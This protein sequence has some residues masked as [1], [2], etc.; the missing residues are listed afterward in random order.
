MSGIKITTLDDG[1]IQ[2]NGA[3]Y[4]LRDQI[5]VRGG[6]WDAAARTWTL[7]AGA[8]TTFEAPPSV[9][10]SRDGSPAARVTGP[11]PREEWTAAEWQNYCLRRRG[12]SGPCCSHATAYWEYAQG[13]THYRCERHGV[14]HSSY[15]G[16]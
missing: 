11:R 16:D 13:P 1:R 10:H 3:T 4:V 6:R 8:D 12:N 7:P 15:T 5:K 14:T 2:L 9:T